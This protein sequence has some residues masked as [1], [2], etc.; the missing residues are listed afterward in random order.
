MIAAANVPKVG[1]FKKVRKFFVELKV[2]QDI[3]RTAVSAGGSAP[4][5][6]EEFSL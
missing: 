4:K 2:D 5:W 3:K 6:N 1:I